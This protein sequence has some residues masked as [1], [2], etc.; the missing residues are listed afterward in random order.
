MASSSWR[1]ALAE[2]GVEILSTGGTAAALAAA[3]V[4]GQAGLGAHRRAGDPRRPREDAASEDPRRPARPRH[5][6]ARA[7]DGGARDR[8]DRSR[9]REPVSVR[10]DDREAGDAARRGDREHRHRRPVDAALGR[11]EPRARRGRRRSRRLRDGDRASCA[12]AAACP[13]G[14]A[15]R[16]RAQGVRAHRRVRRRDRRVPVVDRRRRGATPATQAPAR[17]ELPD[18]LGVQWRRL[19]E[20]RY[21]ENPHQQARVLRGRAVAAARRRPATRPTIAGGRGAR[22]Q[23]ALVQQHPRSRRRARPR[24]SSSPSP[25]RSSSSTTTRAASRSGATS[26]PR[27][28]RAREADATSRVRRHR[29]GQPRGRRGA[30][31]AP[32]RDV[33]RVRR[34]AGLLGRRRATSSRA[35]RTSGWSRRA[36]TWTRADRRARVVDAHDRGRRARAD[37]SITAW[38]I[39]RGA[40]VATKRAPTDAE[41]ADLAFAWRVA[42]HVKS[43]AI[44]F[45]KDGVTRRDRRRPDEPRRLGADLR[46]QGGRQRSRARSSRPTRSSRSATA[47]TCSPQAGAVAVVQPGGSV[48]DDGGDRRRRTSTASRCCSPACATSGTEPPRAPYRRAHAPPAQAPTRVCG[49]SSSGRTGAIVGR[50]QEALKHWVEFGAVPRRSSRAAR[51]VRALGRLLARA[52]RRE[53]QRRVHALWRARE[54]RRVSPHRRV[55]RQWV[56]RATHCLADVMIVPGV[57]YGAAQATVARR[58]GARSRPSDSRLVQQVDRE[59]EVVVDPQPQRQRP[60]LRGDQLADPQRLRWLDRQRQL[61]VTFRSRRAP[62]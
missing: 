8:A 9:G 13:R 39:S 31:E 32:R 46:A 40:K 17:R 23:A 10:G 29:R 45:A 16:A 3:G 21:G 59:V 37:A 52:A 57:H 56:F 58:L 22:R 54:A 1:R 33:P 43:N 27:T 20:L 30:R 26:R 4:A 14:A 12:P 47:S 34:R 55:R 5:R 18:T 61:T 25:P 48:R 49:R 11:E 6:A 35:R 41:R 62:P 50:E 24:A 2:L 7:R 15:A 44:V 51:L 42:K 19:Y 36:A 60:V 38:S 28:A 53:P